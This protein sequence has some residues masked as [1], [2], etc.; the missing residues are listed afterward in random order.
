MLDVESEHIAFSERLGVSLFFFLLLSP[1][2]KYM[3]ILSLCLKTWQKNNLATSY[4]KL[5]GILAA[6]G[7]ETEKQR[8]NSERKPF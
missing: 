4:Y 1:S 6:S 5:H 8:G 2:H 3:I 7:M